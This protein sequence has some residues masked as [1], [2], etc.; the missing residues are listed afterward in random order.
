MTHP[1]RFPSRGAEA[2]GTIRNTDPLPRALMARFG[3]T[4]AVHVVEQV[5]QRLEEEREP[6]FRGQFGGRDLEELRPG[7]VRD[8]ARDTALG[9]LGQLAASARCRRSRSDVRS[10]GSGESVAR[11]PGA[12]QR[13]RDGQGRAGTRGR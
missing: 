6:G 11:D 7:R 3:R 8:R 5:E 9:F 4:A 13:H 10:S 2:T 1:R 12:R